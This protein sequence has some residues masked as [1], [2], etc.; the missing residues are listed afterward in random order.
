MYHFLSIIMY[1][2]KSQP[3][4]YLNNE[5]KYIMQFEPIGGFPPLIRVDDVKISEKTLESRGF[6]TT[7]IVSI[8]KIM[9]SKKKENLFVAFGSEEEDGTDFA[10]EGMFNEK[11]YEYKDVVYKNIPKRLSNSIKRR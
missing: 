5:Y 10:I 7:N 1:I 9:D 2:S 6:A 8:N 11:P 4:Y 3:I